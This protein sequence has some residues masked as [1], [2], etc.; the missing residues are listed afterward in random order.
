M[1]VMP[2]LAHSFTSFDF[3]LLDALVTSGVPGPFPAQ[4]SLRP[5]PDPVDSIIGALKPLSALPNSS[6][7]TVAKG[8][9]V[10]EP[11]IFIESLASAF[12]RLNATKRV[13]TVERY[14]ILSP[15]IILV[16][17]LH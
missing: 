4:K 7:T 5:P 1:S 10:E 2:F 16:M 3:I 14:F 8:Y 6:A 15:F 12:G 9:T 17:Q 13:N 11:T